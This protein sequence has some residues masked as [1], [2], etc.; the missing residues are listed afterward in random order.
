MKSFNKFLTEAKNKGAVFTFGRFNPPTTG[1]GKLVD[2]LKKESSGGYQVMLF[3]SHSN[4]P[5]KN[6]LSHKDKIKYLHAT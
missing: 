6:P 4:D 5:K 3:T 2:K 1:H